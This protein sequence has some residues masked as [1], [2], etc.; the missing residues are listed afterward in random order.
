[1]TAER[2]T[3][4]EALKTKD[5]DSARVI[6]EQTNKLNKLQETANQLKQ[7]ISNT[8]QDCEERNRTLRKE[9]ESVQHHF[10]Q[11]K[12]KIGSYRGDERKKLARLAVIG[13][14]VVNSFQERVDKAESIL[15]QMAL[16]RKLE[17]EAEKVVVYEERDDPLQHDPELQQEA[18]VCLLPLLYA[19]TH[20]LL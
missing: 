1:M 9:K 8:H 12:H 5:Q 15:K 11:M 16:T 7:K 3:Q 13:K 2:R 4:F 14:Q 17:T 19:H 18:C 6:E 20:T 10:Q